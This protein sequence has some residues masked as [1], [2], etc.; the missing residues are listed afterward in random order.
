MGVRRDHGQDLGRDVDVC[1]GAAAVAPT[2]LR[3]L[4]AGIWFALTLDGETD[5]GNKRTMGI[6]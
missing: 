2:S 3:H 5:G 1:P 4:D 6:G